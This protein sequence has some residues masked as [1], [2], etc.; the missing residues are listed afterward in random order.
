MVQAIAPL[1]QLRVRTT[2]MIY[3]YGLGI[4]VIGSHTVMVLKTSLGLCALTV[5]LILSSLSV[6]L[7]EK[8]DA[9]T[10]NAKLGL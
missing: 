5:P 10:M 1:A 7:V 2:A 8:K 9:Q 4:I 6:K 3:A